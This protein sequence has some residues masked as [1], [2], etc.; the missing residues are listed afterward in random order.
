VT[1]STVIAIVMCWGAVACDQDPARSVKIVARPPASASAAAVPPDT[2]T[3]PRLTEWRLEACPP[4]PEDLPGP[5]AARAPLAVTG[6]CA[7]EHRGAVSCESTGDDFIIAFTRKAG[8]GATLVI[9]LNVETYHGPGS[10]DGAQMFV[11]VE[12]GTSIYRWS[13]DNFPITVGPGEKFAVLAT[14]ARLDAE[15]LLVNCAGRVGPQ[16]NWLYDCE[17]RSD[18]SAIENTTEAVSGTLWCDEAVE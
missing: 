17:G 15:P 10:Y 4:P 16:S 8:R 9:Y 3:P 6:P 11:E 1:R 18:A 7:F 14:T 2:A 12:D 13:N 5:S